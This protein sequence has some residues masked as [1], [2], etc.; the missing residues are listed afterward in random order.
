[1][2]HIN[3]KKKKKKSEFSGF[4]MPPCRFVLAVPRF[5]HGIL[6]NINCV[7]FCGIERGK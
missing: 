4:G 1:M 5:V 6:Y 3:C 7:N 2:F